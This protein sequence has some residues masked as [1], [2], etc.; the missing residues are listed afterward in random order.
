MKKL[1]IDLYFKITEEMVVFRDKERASWDWWINL[2]WF[3]ILKYINQYLRI[4]Y[5]YLL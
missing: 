3:T 4:P 5:N 2:E 1:Y